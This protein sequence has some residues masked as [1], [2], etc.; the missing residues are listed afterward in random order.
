MDNETISL[1]EHVDEKIDSLERYLGGRFQDM[2]RHLI[3]KIEAVGAASAIANEVAKEAVTKAEAAVE[4]RLEG[5][6]EL[7]ALVGDYQR[8][9]LPR[10]EADVRLSN[11]ES[12]IDKVETVL[13][14]TS[15][16]ASGLATGWAYLIAAV[17]LLGAVA[18]ILIAVF[19]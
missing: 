15:G 12:R 17:G 9:L 11:I 6:N 5:L 4:R 18:G 14:A 1:R 19:G 13:D 2:E 3:A 16:H 10:A 7:R 8:T